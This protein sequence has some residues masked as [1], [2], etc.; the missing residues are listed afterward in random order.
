MKIPK[1]SR[2]DN[3][4]DFFKAWFRARPSRA[5]ILRRRH[6]NLKRFLQS[7]RKNLQRRKRHTS[8]R[9]E[10][11]AS[12]HSLSLRKS[13]Y[14]LPR[15]QMWRKPRRFKRRFIQR[16]V[17]SHIRMRLRNKRQLRRNKNL[18]S[19][20]RLRS[21][22]SQLKPNQPSQPNKSKPNQLRQLSKSKPNQLNQ[23]NKSKPNQLSKKL[24]SKSLNN[25]LPRIKRR[26]IRK[27]QRL[28]HK[29]Q[30]GVPHPRSKKS[31]KNL[32]ICSKAKLSQS[33]VRCIVLKM[34]SKPRWHL[35]HQL[36]LRL[37]LLHQLPWFHQRKLLRRKEKLLNQ[38]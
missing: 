32:R 35:R 15:R 2:R 1:L 4:K 24:R 13:R 26:R 38:P 7:E 8:T 21:K 25:K 10:S 31:T 33:L 11:R 27:R 34:S 12:T 17:S 6:Q 14:Q 19:K 37:L 28:P 30:Q 22:N 36:K 29:L 3:K 18:L 20:W 5:L 9:R 23:P 16:P